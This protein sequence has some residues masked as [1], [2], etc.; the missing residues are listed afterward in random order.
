MIRLSIESLRRGSSQRRW[1]I[2]RMVLGGCQM[3]GATLSF[4]LLAETGLNGWSVGAVVATSLV[5]TV[6]VFLFRL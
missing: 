3:F 2:V 5:T 6:S 1:A 4:V